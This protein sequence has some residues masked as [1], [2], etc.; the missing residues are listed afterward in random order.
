MGKKSRQKRQEVEEALLQGMAKEVEQA[1]REEPPRKSEAEEAEAQLDELTTFVDT[2]E[3]TEAD[4]D[5]LI[6]EIKSVYPDID[7][8]SGGR[9]PRG[10]APD[11]SP[12]KLE[13]MSSEEKAQMAIEDLYTLID[14]VEGDEQEEGL[15]SG[16]P[17]EEPRK[18]IG[19]RDRGRT[20]GLTNGAR[21]RTN[22]LTNGQGRGRTNGLTNGVNGRT[23][24]LTNGRG[25]VNGL[26]N[27]RDRKSV[28]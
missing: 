6:D 10:P 9:K 15:T 20:N 28:V 25:S 22:G 11:I 14:E 19:A 26:T 13:S 3:P 5:S 7:G 1:P 4:V 27:G 21:G 8:A 23:N 12:E 24:G 2:A 16:A 18:E 17:I